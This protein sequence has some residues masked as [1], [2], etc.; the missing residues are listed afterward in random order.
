VSQFE[1][2]EWNDA[3]AALHAEVT[4]GFTRTDLGAILAAGITRPELLCDGMLYAGALHSL[5]GPPDCGKTTLAL[6]WALGLLRQGRTVV[7]LDEETGPE[8]TALK[9]LAMGAAAG[10]LGR[11][12]Y[13]AFPGRQWGVADLVAL[14][15]VIAAAEPALVIW[16]SV[17]AHAGRAMLDEDKAGDA[18][19]LWSVF[20]RP[21]RQCNAAVVG[22]DHDA[23]HANGSRYARGSSAKLA[24]VDVAYKVGIERAFSRQ[25]DGALKLSVTKDRRGWLHRDHK[26]LVT[27]EP[28]AF[29]IT[30]VEESPADEVRPATQA[31]L[32]AAMHDLGKPS[33]QGQ[34]VD[35]IRELYGSGFSRETASRHL[36]ALLDLGLVDRLEQGRGAAVLWS[37][38]ERKDTHE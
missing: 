34:L 1:D 30:E 20:A 14:D 21:A 38:Y 18:T 37:L 36:T 15:D 3:Y 23:K 25:Q 17:A 29:T 22:I 24:T 8:Q 11:L 31:K 7:I 9:L 2:Q 28:L 33:T 27:R 26:A 32:L 10:E 16:D 13:Y 35:R 6:S 4:G 5:T 19:R 12:H